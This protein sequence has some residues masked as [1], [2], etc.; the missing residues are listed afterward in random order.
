MKTC[1]AKDSYEHA[2]CRHL[3]HWCMLQVCCAS[4]IHEFC[5][6]NECA[7]FPRVC[8]HQERRKGGVLAIVYTSRCRRVV[9]FKKENE[10]V[11]SKLNASPTTCCCNVIKKNIK[12][13]KDNLQTNSELEVMP[14]P[15]KKKKRMH[16]HIHTHRHDL[17]GCVSL[18][19]WP[20]R[21]YTF[22]KFRR[23]L[24]EAPTSSEVPKQKNRSKTDVQGSQVFWREVAIFSRK[25]NTTKTHVQ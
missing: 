4:Y 23:M 9:N 15:K 21:L 13:K 25:D 7:C 18:R 22:R 8:T 11:K 14:Q 20:Y 24:K 2:G 1:D 10:E 5:E 19:I 12:A 17:K 16:S 6:R 3:V